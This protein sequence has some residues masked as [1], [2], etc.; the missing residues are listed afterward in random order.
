VENFKLGDDRGLDA[1]VKQLF[2]WFKGEFTKLK[3]DYEV[4]IESREPV[5][6]KMTPKN[7]V[8]KKFIAAIEVEFTKGEDEISS[9][10]IIEPLQKGD[11]E[12]GYTLYAFKDTELDTDIKDDEFKLKG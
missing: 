1:V 10:K 9:V 8:V 6:L 5:K 12:P 2:T 4:S 3:A 7:E 11:T